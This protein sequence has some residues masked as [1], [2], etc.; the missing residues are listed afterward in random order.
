MKRVE[1]NLVLN[2]LENKNWI[3]NDIANKSLLT[4]EEVKMSE[5]YLLPTIFLLI[6]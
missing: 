5:K 6:I 3:D 4:V 1:F 2:I